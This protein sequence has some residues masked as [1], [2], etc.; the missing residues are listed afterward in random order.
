MPSEIEQKA[1][2]QL[3]YIFDVYDGAFGG[4]ALKMKKKEW[5]TF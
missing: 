3:T 5:A 4:R 1:I 2:R